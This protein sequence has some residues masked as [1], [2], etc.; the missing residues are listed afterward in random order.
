LKIEGNTL[1]IQT[2]KDIQH[3]EAGLAQIELQYISFVIST[4]TTLLNEFIID[5]IQNK[6]RRAGVS[7]KVIDRTYLDVKA[8]KEFQ[9]ISFHIKSDYVSESGFA[10][11]KM[12]EGGRKAYFIRPNK[13]R[14]L[15]WIKQ[16][17][18]YFSKGHKIPEKKAGMYVF[19]T[20]QSGQSKVQKELNKRTKKWFKDIIR[21][22]V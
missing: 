13:K 5:P 18:R 20:I 9:T 11:A 17:I 16:G 2:D 4:L 7:S 6:M 1:I 21:G 3:L 22:R 12:I 10:V 15:S 8:E 19:D 14:F